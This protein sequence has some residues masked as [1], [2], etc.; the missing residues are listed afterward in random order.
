ME[1]S[2]KKMVDDS[3]DE[4]DNKDKS[5]ESKNGWWSQNTNWK[6]KW[7]ENKEDINMKIKNELKKEKQF[8]CGFQE[9]SNKIMSLKKEIETLVDYKTKNFS[10][11]SLIIFYFPFAYWQEVI[12]S[13]CTLPVSYFS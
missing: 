10:L 3:K 4:N 13:L 11:F 12:V 8:N 7:S 2:K 1:K 6:R 9:I 5:K